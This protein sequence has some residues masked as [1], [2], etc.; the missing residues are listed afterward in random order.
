MEIRLQKYMAE[1]GIASRRA[2]EKLILD[3]KVT[4]NGFVVT[5]L[6]TKVDPSRDSV[7]Y[8]GER[9]SI[10][11]K[12]VYYMLYK[13]V[14]VVSTASDDQGRDTVVDMIPSK[15]RLF[16]V[17]RLDFMTSGLIIMTNDGDL[18]YKLTHPKHEVAKTYIAKVTPKPDDIKLD[19]IRN[20]VKLT[21]YETSP[22]VIK[23]IGHGPDWVSYSIVL[24]EGKN[25]QI[26]KMFEYAGVK[27][28]NLERVSIGKLTLKGLKYG[29]Y[30]ELTVSEVDYLKGL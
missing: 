15:H 28:L 21:E 1:A 9:I 12:L 24:K 25:R 3:G 16:P 14:R 20:G 13:P 22:C 23:S 4:V 17:G 19:E 26:R 11:E 5:E 27:V 30:R 29:G 8:N 6:G 10:D 2:S 7:E 18:T